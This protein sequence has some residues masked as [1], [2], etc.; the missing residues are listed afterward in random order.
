MIE[1]KNINYKYPG[2]QY[3]VFNNLNCKIGEPGFHALFGLSGVGKSTLARM[4]AGQLNQYTG[5]IE[6]NNTDIIF[7]SYNLERLPG[8][9]SVGEHILKITPEKNKDRID[10]IVESFGLY[11]CID[12]GFSHLS[13][14][15]RNR[16][17]LARYLLQDFDCL[18]MDESLANVDEVTR[19]QIILKIKDMYPQK[20]F[21]YISHSVAEV[22]MFCKNIIVLR[23]FKK[24]PQA[25]TVFGQDNKTGKSVARKDLEQT[26]L[27]IVNVS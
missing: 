18:I 17:N 26:M 21:I 2:T 24:S 27:E 10:E 7:Y 23:N 15:Q 22:S 20:S 8:W 9:S 1:C 6:R 5:V 14:G 16:I 25:I 11:A 13:L 19:E 3:P 12:S 4:V